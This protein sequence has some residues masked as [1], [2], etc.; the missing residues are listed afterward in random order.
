MAGI[1]W[2]ASGLLNGLSEFS[3][4]ADAAMWMYVQTGATKMQNYTKKNRPWTDRTG[5]AR[6]RLT[7]TPMTIPSGYRIRL[8]HG[9]DYGVYLELAHEK[10]YAIINPTIQSEGPEIVKGFQNLME[11]L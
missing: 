1:K 5:A 2:D 6:Q 11:K 4:K 7:G 10:K 9:V 3:T 8:A